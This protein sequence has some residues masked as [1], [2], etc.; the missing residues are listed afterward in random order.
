MTHAKN[1]NAL[2]G[3]KVKKDDPMRQNNVL[4]YLERVG[5]VVQNNPAYPVTVQS[6]NAKAMSVQAASSR[7][8]I[9]INDIQYR[10]YDILRDI[11]LGDIDEIY[12]NTV[13]LEPS[14]NLYIG[15]VVI[16]T[17]SGT[18]ANTNTKATNTDYLIK[19]GFSPRLNFVNSTYQSTDDDGFENFGVI[20][21]E[22]FVTQLDGFYGAN[23]NPLTT[24]KFYI[25]IEGI[26]ADGKLISIQKVVE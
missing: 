3:Y 25:Q 24:E 26:A 14:I 17:K 5:F 2:T 15:K 4:Y 10:D 16:Y 19:E 20:H 13:Y 9:I 7:A 8:L 22:P 18:L 23:F 12:T 11:L 1:N 6:R 21:W